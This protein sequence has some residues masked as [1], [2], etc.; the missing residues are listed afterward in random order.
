M[1]ERGG[2]QGTVTGDLPAAPA[3]EVGDAAVQ[4][5]NPDGSPG[6]QQTR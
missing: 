1:I 6:V 2:T 4:E 3:A 5:R